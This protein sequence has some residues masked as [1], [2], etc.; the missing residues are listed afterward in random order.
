MR[1]AHDMPF[2]ARLL[3]EG[4]AVFRLWAPAEVRVELLLKHP[5]GDEAIEAPRGPDGWREVRVPGAE[6]GQRYQWRVHG[7]LRDED[8]ARRHATVLVLQFP[9]QAVF[10]SEPSHAIRG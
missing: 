1:I 2:G 5:L 6:A 9:R 4:G 7:D 10:D 3:P 8:H